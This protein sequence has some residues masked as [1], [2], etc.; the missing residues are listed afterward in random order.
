MKK[1]KNGI[2]VSLG[3]HQRIVNQISRNQTRLILDIAN[4][5]ID[6]YQRGNKIIFF[7]NGGSAADAQHLATELV[8]RFK[9]NRKSI[10]AVALTTNT[11]LLTAVGNDYSF[12]KIFARQV[13]SIV[14]KGDLVVGI[15][16]SGNATNV[17]EG[18][19]QAKRQGAYTIGLT[20]RT[21]GK[22]K[23]FVDLLFPVPSEDT[24]RI[25]EAHILV[26]HIICDLVENTLFG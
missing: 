19:K 1:E 3:E 17:I 26:G 13:E 9:K 24:A 12:S 4:L 16:T 10:P 15:S 18:I 11:S 2:K 6:C 20:G 7:G 25:Q 5:F 8:V 14:N 22:L 21:G 23:S